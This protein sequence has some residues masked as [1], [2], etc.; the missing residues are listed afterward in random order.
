MPQSL[1]QL[2]LH[3]VF[4]TKNRQPSI[5]DSLSKELYGYIGGILNNIDCLPIKI[6]GY[7]DHIHILCR[8]SKKIT[9]VKLIETIKTSSSKWVKTKGDEY[10]NFYWQ[11]GYGAF[12]VSPFDVE[13]VKMYIENQNEN[14]QKKTFKEEYLKFLID[15]HIDFNEKYLWD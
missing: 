4:S 10:M 13:R 14:H 1:T 2:Y 11:D 5:K 9:V 12:T 6:G 8:I 7:Q 15:N 3:I